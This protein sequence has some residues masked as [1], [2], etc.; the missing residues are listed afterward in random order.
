VRILRSLNSK[1]EKL[2]IYFF[3]LKQE[4]DV[5]MSQGLKVPLLA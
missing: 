1:H 4:A 3:D 2:S 5:L